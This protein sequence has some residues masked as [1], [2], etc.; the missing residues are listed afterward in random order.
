MLLERPAHTRTPSQS[1]VAPLD[2]VSRTLLGCATSHLVDLFLPKKLHAARRHRCGERA[3]E[4]SRVEE[5]QQRVAAVDQMHV[6]AHRGEGAGVLAADHAGADDD[7]ASGQGAEM[8]QLIGVVHAVVFEGKDRRTKRRGSRRDENLFPAQARLRQVTAARAHVA[9]GCKRRLSGGP[10][11]SASCS[12]RPCAR[13]SVMVG[14]SP[15]SER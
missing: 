11:F 8:Q 6:H 7:Q 15:N 12:S 13:R 2:S 9:L 1:S 5:R 3:C 4:I 10:V 14:L